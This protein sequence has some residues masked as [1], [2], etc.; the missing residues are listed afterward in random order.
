LAIWWQLT[1]AILNRSARDPF[2]QQRFYF[3]GRSPISTT[4]RIITALYTGPA[5][6]AISFAFILDPQIE[7]LLPFKLSPQGSLDAR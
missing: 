3:I 7:A 2:S 5:Q 6:L 1:S 4:H